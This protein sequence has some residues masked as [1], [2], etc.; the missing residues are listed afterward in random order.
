LI[1]ADIVAI[2]VFILSFLLGAGL[3]FG[4]ILKGVTNGVMGK[5]LSIIATYFLL[6]IILNVSFVQQF[7]Q[8]ITTKLTESTA[9]ICKFLI[10]IRVDIIAV[11][12]ILFIVVQ[13][14]RTLIVHLI[15]SAF[16]VDNKA[17]RIINK[18]LGCTLAFA[19]MLALVLIVFQIA[20]WIEGQGQLY[21]ALEGSFFGLD[22]LYVSN[23]LSALISTIKI[24]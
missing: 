10:T 19:I 21:S 12:V 9:P 17:I 23:P 8:L 7:M 1:T 13:L 15:S 2:C 6:G 16:E 5:I 22:K 24:I 14:V 4:K 18:S 3:G 11:A 20:T